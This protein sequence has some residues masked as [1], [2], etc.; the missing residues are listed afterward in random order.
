[1]GDS[2]KLE[3]L[4]LFISRHGGDWRLWV[5]LLAGSVAVGIWRAKSFRFL[6]EYKARE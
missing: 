4:I 1:M 6:V 5:G 3:Q 2:D